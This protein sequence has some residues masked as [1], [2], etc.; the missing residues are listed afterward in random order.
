TSQTPATPLEREIAQLERALVQQ[1]AVFSDSNPNIIALRARIDAAGDAWTQADQKVARLQAQLEALPAS[2]REMEPGDTELKNLQRQL[3]AV[4]QRI[5]EIESS[6]D[7]AGATEPEARLAAAR[8]NGDDA[9]VSA[10]DLPAAMRVLE[11]LAQTRPE[12]REPIAIYLGRVQWVVN[13]VI[14]AQQQMAAEA[15]LARQAHQ[16]LRER[17]L[18]EAMEADETITRLRG[19][20]GLTRRLYNA[21]RDGSP[22]QTREDIDQQVASLEAELLALRDQLALA[23]RRVERTVDRDTDV[24]AALLK[25]QGTESQR[26]QE[27][28]DGRTEALAAWNAAFLAVDNAAELAGDAKL[29]RVLRRI[30]SATRAS[31]LETTRGRGLLQATWDDAFHDEPAAQLAG[32]TTTSPS[33]WE[34]ALTRPADDEKDTDKSSDWSDLEEKQDAKP[35]HQRGRVDAMPLRRFAEPVNVAMV[36]AV[37]QDSAL[38]DDVEALREQA[39]QLRR[40]IDFRRA[41]LAGDLRR[42]SDRLRQDLA[43]AQTDSRNAETE[44]TRA[45]NVLADFEAELETVRRD[46]D[47]IATLQSQ[48]RLADEA[49]DRARREA[50]DATERLANTIYPL[51]HDP[52]TDERISGVVDNRPR[53]YVITCVSIL[54]L[55]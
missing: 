9:E 8:L 17:R 13:D 15:A 20:I 3:D 22:G 48:K 34:E 42:R 23:K 1:S 53:Y 52:S 6:A 19:Q 44:A 25:A 31:I 37:Q 36:L 33:T 55:M 40:Q 32:E 27:L 51:P 21:A 54:A 4:E 38:P 24:M 50:S 29:A 11:E 47:R 46:Q 26:E 30:E 16:Q 2:A 35:N 12:L 28:A 5:A 45:R 43:A 10:D 41:E 14:P 18:G 7:A 39:A 49:V